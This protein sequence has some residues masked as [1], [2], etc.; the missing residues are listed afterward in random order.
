[1]NEPEP[2][3][4]AMYEAIRVLEK[5]GFLFHY[6]AD[7]DATTEAKLKAKAALRR[8]ENRNRLPHP[9]AERGPVDPKDWSP[10]MPATVTE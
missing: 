1:M 10:A 2:S 9:A 8:F 3:A 4:M 5:R 6:S 7:A